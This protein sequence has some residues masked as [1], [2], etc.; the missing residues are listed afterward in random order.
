MRRQQVAYAQGRGLSSRGACALLVVARST[1]GYQSRWAVRDAPAITAMR[2][3]AGQYPRYG[4]RRI[5]IFLKRAG[6]AMGT[7][8][9]HRLWRQASTA[10]AGLRRES[11]VGVRRRVRH[12]REWA[13][14]E[15]PHRHRITSCKSLRVC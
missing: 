1:L 8:R 10:R 13:A 9:T 15:M 2:E 7:D 4:Y 14:A 12:V 6:H 3:W 5:R 11:R